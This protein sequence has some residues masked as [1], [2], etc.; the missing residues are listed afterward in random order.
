MD[1][2]IFSTIFHLVIRHGYFLMFLVMCAEGPIV[3]AAAAFAVS[4]GFFSLPVVFILSI[5]GDIVPDAIY[6]YLGYGARRSI[7][8]KYGHYFGLPISR[9]TKIRELLSQHAIKTIVALKFTPFVSLPGFMLV[10]SARISYSK[11]IL[12]C[13]LIT[14]FKTTLFIITGYYFGM[15]YNIGK[16]IKVGNLILFLILVIFGILYFAYR[17]LFWWLGRQI[18]K[19]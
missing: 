13:F 1:L 15:L 7:I 11:F 4:Q 18:E 6:F 9:V 8:D 10:G 12:T 17:K 16:Y 2:T 3:T 5:L 19:I 14:L